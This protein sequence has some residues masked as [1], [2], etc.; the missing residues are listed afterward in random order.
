MPIATTI[1]AAGAIASGAA[2]SL[3]SRGGARKQ[4]KYQK[5][6]NEQQHSRDLENWYRQN[7][8]NSPIAQMRRYAEAGLNPRLI[9]SSG[10]SSS[11]NAGSVPGYPDTSAPD[12]QSERGSIG[13]G[14]SQSLNAATNVFQLLS[15]RE[16]L[17]SQKLDNKL[18]ETEVQYAVDDLSHLDDIVYG[19]SSSKGTIGLKRQQLLSS[20]VGS[21]LSNQE[22]A[23]N[24]TSGLPASLQKTLAETDFYSDRKRHISAQIRDIDSRIGLRKFERDLRKLELQWY[25]SSKFIK[26]LAPFLKLLSR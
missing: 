8:Y 15:Q 7:E 9:Y 26:N 13:A 19:S 4:Y 1:G 10:Q 25:N 23:F 20:L 17:R 22:R 16:S 14:V 5:K 21:D 11:G 12:F 2:S 3:I 6:L 18:K 24:V